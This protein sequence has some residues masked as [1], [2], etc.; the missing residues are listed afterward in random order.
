MNK[1]IVRDLSI[2]VW[3]VEK[4]VSRLFIKIG[5]NSW[6]ELVCYVLEYGLINWYSIIGKLKVKIN[7]IIKI[8]DLF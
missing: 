8:F 7:C 4:Y 3:N 2:S 1:E 6:M 5:M